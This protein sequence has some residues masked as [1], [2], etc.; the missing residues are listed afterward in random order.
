MAT[1][2]QGPQGFKGARGVQ[3]A[4]GWGAIGSDTGPTG[5]TGPIGWFPNQVIQESSTLV[6]LS[7]A[8]VSTLYRVV[9][10]PQGTTRNLEYS[11][12]P[13]GGFF[14]FTNQTSGTITLQPPAGGS[15]IDGLT[16]GFTLPQ[17]RSVMLIKRLGD[18]LVSSYPYSGVWAG[19]GY[20]EDIPQ[21]GG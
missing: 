18:E 4:T 15:M 14:V 6:S 2:I 5:P 17:T 3:G 12:A 19:T 7:S 13:E 1:G 11:T 10:G 21:E 9:T 8:D 20:V 16:T